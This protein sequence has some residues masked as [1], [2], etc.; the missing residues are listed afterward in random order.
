MDMNSLLARIPYLPESPTRHAGVVLAAAMLVALIA[1]FAFRQLVHRVTKSTGTD[2][3]DRIADI[4]KGPS[5]WSFVFGGPGWPRFRSISA[6]ESP[7][8]SGVSC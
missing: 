2:V 7:M 6:A 1:R 8:R 5:F 4:R 3:D